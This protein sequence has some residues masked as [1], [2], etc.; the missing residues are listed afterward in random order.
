MKTLSLF[1]AVAAFA[2]C[3]DN[4][5]VNGTDGGNTH[6]DGGGTPAVPQLGT[7]I[8]RM[9]RPAINTALNHGF[10]ATAAAGT[11]KDAYNADGSPGGWSSYAAQFAANLAILDSLDTG[12]GAGYGCGN[13]ALYNGNVSGGGSAAATSYA[14]LAGILTD[15]ELNLDTSIGVC[16]LATS[17]SN[18]LSVEFAVVTTVTNTTCGGRA[19]TNDVM[20]TSYTLLA[21]GI[22]GFSVDGKF[23]P[24]FSDGATVHADVSN[25]NFPFLGTPH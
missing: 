20:A 16:D 6:S 5:K 11:A 7:E 12:L 25:D 21:I 24:G 13:Q 1:L 14:T 3:G 23:T 22:A 4:L 15:D 9:G 19:P 2:G 18:Y 17:H 8:D 10:D